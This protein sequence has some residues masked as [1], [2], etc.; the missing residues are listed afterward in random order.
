MSMTYCKGG[1]GVATKI[2]YDNLGRMK[3]HPDFHPMHGQPFSEEELC[4]LAKFYKYDGRLS[5]SL[6]LD[7]PE[8]SVQKKYLSLK[9]NGLLERYR[10]L[11]HYG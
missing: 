10:Q 5:V 6:A 3:Y 4:Y 8:A 1:R 7:R 2:Q 9:N 11:E